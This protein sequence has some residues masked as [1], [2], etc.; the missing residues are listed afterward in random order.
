MH[1]EERLRRREKARRRTRRQRRYTGAAVLALGAGGALALGVGALAGG[2]QAEQKATAAPAAQLPRGGRSILPDNRV[3]AYYGAPQDRELGALGIGSPDAAARRL[4]RQARPYARHGR[5][6]LPAL[7][8][9]ATVANGSPGAGGRYASRQRAATVAR[10]LRAAR[11][12]KALLILDIQPGRVPFMREVR[13]FRRFL[14]EPDVS[15]A[16]DPEWSVGPGQLPGRQIGSTDAAV[17]NEAGR[18]LSGIVRAHRLP[19]KLLV[20]HRFTHD[21]IRNESSLRSQRGVALI[22]NVDGFG[23]RA[24]KAAKYREFTRSRRLARVRANGFKLFYKEDTRMMTP[25]GVLRLKPPPDLVVY[26]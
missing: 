22:V 25:R 10:Y 6:V 5:P 3:V 11:R 9:I 14:A 18:Y 26:E 12:H 20:V 16:L 23:T 17:V 24:V 8:L 21:M 2:G 1:R 13:A 15:L 19:Q 4:E 7:E